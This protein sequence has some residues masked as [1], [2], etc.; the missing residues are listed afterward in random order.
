[1]LI[2]NPKMSIPAT[3]STGRHG[4]LFDGRYKA[5]VV[6]REEYLLKLSAGLDWT[7]DS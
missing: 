5:K 4:P 6:E 3:R 2:P 7:E 1:M